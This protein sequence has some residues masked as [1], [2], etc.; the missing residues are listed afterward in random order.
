MRAV[1]CTEFGPLESLVI[2]ERPVPDPGEGMVVVEVAA[3]GVNFVDG[4]ICMGQYQLKPPTPFVPGSEV[5]GV[6]TAIGPG[7]AGWSIG[8]RVLVFCGMG[9]FAGQVVAP[10]LSLVAVPEVLDLAAAAALIQSYCTMLF[11]LTRRTTVAP[12][13]W[14]LVMGAGGGI[15][16]AAVDVARA[17]GA[18]VIAA[19]STPD[20]LDAAVAMGAEATIAYEEEDLKIRARE[21]SGGGVDVIVDPVGGRHAESALRAT[22][23]LGR[24][25]V[26]GFA[27]GP[28]PSIPLN[29][30]LLNNRTVVGVDWGGWTFKDP[31]G[32]RALIDELMGMVATGRLHPT[33]PASR[34]LEEAAVVMESLIDRSITG[35]VVLVP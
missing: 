16:L 20:K 15:G 5:A 13:E 8:D 18:R 26:I 25:C 10:A 24:Y 29:Q 11:T 4:L 3:A 14:V 23:H 22:R 12:G 31:F 17:L 21:L 28:I 35:K 1:V 6:I 2:E 34:P 33:T 7:V 9:G 30:V 27:S 19:A 32:N